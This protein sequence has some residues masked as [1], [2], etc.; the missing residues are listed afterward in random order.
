MNNVKLIFDLEVLDIVKIEIIKLIKN[1]VQVKY[2]ALFLNF[3]LCLNSMCFKHSQAN[4]IIVVLNIV[5]TKM[6]CNL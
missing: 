3:G 6:F 5:W 4:N 2:K 1:K